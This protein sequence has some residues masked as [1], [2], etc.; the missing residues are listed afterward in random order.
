M[1]YIVP[2]HVAAQPPLHR[3]KND[4][5][6]CPRCQQWKRIISKQCSICRIARPVIP[7][8]SDPT[9]RHIPLTKGQFSIVNAY[10]YAW[11]MQWVWHAQWVAKMGAYYAVRK[12]DGKSVYMHQ[13]ILGLK[14]GL[15][16]HKNRNTLDNRREN[17]RPCNHAQNA[18][19]TAKHR[20]NTSGFKGVTWSISNNGWVAQCCVHGKHHY[21]GT[22]STKEEAAAAYHKFA[23]QKR[24]EFARLE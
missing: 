23:I 10:L 22:H 19:N 3:I 11:L 16:D 2:K 20:N 18:A 24:G 13:Q 8:P 12:Q 7:Q 14:S 1:K 5:D 17:I 21:L 9:I 6:H 15:T 4:Y